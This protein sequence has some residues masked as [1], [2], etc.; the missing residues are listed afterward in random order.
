[1][2]SRLVRSRSSGRVFAD[3]EALPE[4]SVHSAELCFFL[5][6]SSHEDISWCHRIFTPWLAFFISLASLHGRKWT[7]K[8]YNGVELEELRRSLPACFPVL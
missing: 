2:T 8:F 5:L 4:S 6:F 3:Q 7:R 1:M